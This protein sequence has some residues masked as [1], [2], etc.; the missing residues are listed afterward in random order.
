MRKSLERWRKAR[1]TACIAAVIALVALL[2]VAAQAS[3]IML[4][5]KDVPLK[6]VVNLLMQQSGA[7]VVIQD[8]AAL[9]RKISASLNDVPLEK[10][11][12][13]IVRGA[14][15]SYR[16]TEDG[17]YI[18]GGSDIDEPEL[19][20]AVAPALPPVVAP[21]PPPVK[22]IIIVPIKLMHSR[23][24]ELLRLTGWDGVNPMKNCEPVYP[25]KFTGED[26][27]RPTERG[28]HL[29]NGNTGQTYSPVPGM[30]NGQ[31]IISTIDPASLTPGAGRTADPMTGAAQYPDQ[32]AGRPPY[33]TPGTPPRNPQSSTTT[34]SSTSGNF[35]WPEGIEDAKP[36]DLDNSI[37]VKGTED[38]I[39]KFKKIIRMLDV[40][41]QQVQVKA[42]FVEVKTTDVKSFGIDWSLQRLNESFATAF[43]PSGNVVVGFATGNLAASL[44]T[45][46]TSD[47]GTIINS[48][49]IS[50]INN[51]NA[52]ISI[53]TVIPYWT[54]YAT[55]TDTTVV[56]NS[57]VNFIDVDTHLDILPRVNGDGTIT[58]ILRP[59]VSDT[60]NVVT[61]PNGETIPEERTQE[62]FTQRRV[63]NGETIVVG[64]F[65]RKNDSESYQKIPV[66]G[67]LPLVGSLFRTVSRTTE[68]RELLIF[69][70]PTIIPPTGGGTVGAMPVP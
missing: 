59:G 17:T 64:G 34:S 53:S 40:P 4:Q 16:K 62:L 8:A 22:E 21:A 65:I 30:A 12:T 68:D 37:I 1:A 49:I 69:I 35:L 19:S 70:T 10:A 25:A 20:K 56:N 36:F 60:G 57:Y 24:T 50:T 55:V 33:T 13:Y 39:E 28:V 67:D 11:L 48:P 7:N 45:Q 61:G 29:L 54:S 2:A 6:E 46:L 66:L 3:G 58:M 27:T 15:V 23:P 38:A 51:Q 42:E 43:G 47:V 18:I 63:A 14:G 5:I 9:D 44:K 41:P 32:N 31:P 26:T 52:S